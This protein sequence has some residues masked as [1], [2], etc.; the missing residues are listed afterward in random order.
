M[1]DDKKTLVLVKLRITDRDGDYSA[2]V[3]HLQFGQYN[4]SRMGVFLGCDISNKKT[5][6]QFILFLSLASPQSSML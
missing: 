6:D 1:S 2:I 3:E 5:Q 4:A